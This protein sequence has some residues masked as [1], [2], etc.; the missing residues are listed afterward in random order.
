MMINW[1]GFVWK[2]SWPNFKVLSGHSPGGTEENHENLSQDSRSQGMRFKPRTYRIRSRSANHSITTFGFNLV[3]PRNATGNSSRGIRQNISPHSA[4]AENFSA[5]NLNIPSLKCGLNA[6][7]QM[8]LAWRN[9]VCVT[10]F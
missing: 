6:C 5:S 10:I 2:R 3:K 9:I 7:K 8:K 1:K 4:I